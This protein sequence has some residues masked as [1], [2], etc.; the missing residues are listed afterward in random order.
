MKIIFRQK[1]TLLPALALLSAFTFLTACS[2]A[3]QSAQETSAPE[4][5]A[6]AMAPE[7]EAPTPA[8]T[9]TP[10]PEQ[11]SLTV[12]VTA[13]ATETPRPTPTAVPTPSPTPTPTPTPEPTPDPYDG[14]E[15]TVLA[16]D[17]RFFYI[18]LTDVLKQRITGMSYPEDPSTCRIGYDELRY[19]RIL[20]VD[21]DGNTQE[22]ELM[23]NYQVADDVLHIFYELYT[24]GYQL[25]SVRL[26]DDYGEPGDDNVSMAADNTSAFNYRRV[27]GS[28]KLSW[29]SYGCAIDINP[30]ENPYIN[31]KKVSPP[32]GKEYKNRKTKRPH[33]I[34]HSDLAYKTFRAYGW[35]W[36]G[37]FS[38]DKDYQHFYKELNYKR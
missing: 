20:Y 7:T 36:G 9:F 12:E 13:A 15:R 25:C 1:N 28:K 8:P 5:S 33:M 17:E 31:G 11:V 22:G 35:K 3:A 23:V 38:G 26:V 19:V 37:D 2:P 29:H 4:P 27:S 32:A 16:E 30:V 14:A 18:P 10:A 6:V 24:A 34:D 21:F